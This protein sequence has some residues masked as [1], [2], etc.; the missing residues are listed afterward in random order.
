MRTAL[1]ILALVLAGCAASPIGSA[2]GHKKMSPPTARQEQASKEIGEPR[3]RFAFGLKDRLLADATTDNFCFSPLSADLCLSMLLNGTVGPTKDALAKTLSLQGKSLDMVNEGNYSLVAA[4]LGDSFACANSIWMQTTDTV[5]PAFK[6][7]IEN[8]YHGEVFAVPDF[9][10]AIVERINGWTS[11]ETKGR[12]P[13]LFADL[14]PQTSVVLVNAL[15]FDGKWICPFP[16]G[17]TS[18]VGFTLGGGQAVTTATM[19]QQG[20]FGYAEADGAKAIRMGY[21]GGKFSMVFILPPPK[22]SADAFLR[23]LTAKSFDALVTGL[24]S[25]L[26]DVAIP[27]FEF[28]GSYNLIPP[29]SAMGMAPLFTDANLSGIADRLGNQTSIGQVI[30]KTYIKVYEEGTEAAAATGIAG[31]TASAPRP[32]EPKVFHADRPFVFALMHDGSGTIVFMGLVND[33]R[34]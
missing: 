3:T 13:K 28:R 21:M 14:D 34:S 11:E 9:G 33:P 17:A 22:V 23:G 1:P 26:V 19:H 5:K 10:P 24:S 20:H 18:P 32:E 25:G 4:L 2:G 31:A 27:K 15:T 8:S 7:T 6:D 16:K 12:I 29:L 30:H